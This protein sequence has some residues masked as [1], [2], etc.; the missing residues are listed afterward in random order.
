[1]LQHLHISNYALIEN[2]DVD[3]SDGLT[4]ITGETGAGKSILLGALNLLAGG[5]PEA[6]IIKQGA[7][8][9]VVEA[10]F[11]DLSQ[12]TLLLLE[13]EGYDV[14]P[15]CIVRREFMATGKNRAFV[16]DSPATVAFL[17]KLS[18]QLIDIHSQH[19]NLLLGQHHFLLQTLDAIIPQKQIDDY[20]K[21]YAAWRDCVEQLNRLKTESEKNLKEE[22]FLRFQHQQLAEADLQPDELE[23]LE[24]ESN[25]LE[26]ASEIK[27]H[28]YDSLQ[29]L[30]GQQDTLAML[31][32]SENSLQHIAAV[33]PNAQS[34]SE[35][36]ASV[37]IELDDIVA[38]IENQADE[39][40]L[41]PK[42]LAFVQERLDALYSLLKRH[43][44][45]TVA[46]LC[47]IRQQLESR[48]NAIDDYSENLQQAEKQLR[49]S[50]AEVEAAGLALTKSRQAVAAKVEKEILLKIQQL[51]MPHAVVKFNFQRTD[52]PAANGYDAI[53][54]LFSFNKA[55]NP[56]NVTQIASGGETSRLMLALK[57][58]MSTQ[59]N[60]PTI[61]FDEIDSGVSGSM[62]EKMALEMDRMA[63]CRQVICI[64][65]LPQ[66]AAWGKHHFRVYKAD[67]AEAVSSHIEKL[68]DKSRVTEIA[69][70]LS[71]ESLTQAAIDN[72]KSLLSHQSDQL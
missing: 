55:V 62:A 9:C 52:E 17:K 71:G 30:T 6:R 27:Q 46:E 16:N 32:D 45:T 51:G 10:E 23:A 59:K 3:L 69:N 11:A 61:I 65:H 63:T 33:Y 44:A 25:L 48:L 64:T 8:K 7:A 20:A 53:T 39:V 47:A 41:D 4:V 60:L 18:E 68:S 15:T 38:E 58:F 43:N 28:L 40:D 22:E 19:Q 24:E 37:R 1:M 31:R 70:M 50:L 42:R 14:E 13:E 21:A 49:L 5:K 57:S 2:L 34:L 54:L 72:A 29:Q 12:S 67:S 36:L 35:R 26:H 56:Q 66:I